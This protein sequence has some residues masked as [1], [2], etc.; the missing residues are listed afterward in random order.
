MML[1][2]RQESRMKR[3]VVPVIPSILS[4]MFSEFMIPTTQTIVNAALIHG[5]CVISMTL[6]VI[7]R[8]APHKI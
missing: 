5:I 3:E 1:L 2:A 8:M 6:W 7:T 4:S